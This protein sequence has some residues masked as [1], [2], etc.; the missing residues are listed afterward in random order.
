LIEGDDGVFDVALDGEM[1]FS[2]QES[3]DFAAI[4]RM[5]ELVQQRVDER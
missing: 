3:G 2:K 4:G 1:V 5:V